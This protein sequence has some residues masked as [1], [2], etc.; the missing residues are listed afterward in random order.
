MGRRLPSPRQ[1]SASFRLPC[2]GLKACPALPEGS[3]SFPTSC[4]SEPPPH[5]LSC[6]S[7]L[8]VNLVSVPFPLGTHPHPHPTQAEHSSRPKT[9]QT[10]VG[11]TPFVRKE[12]ISKRGPFG[13]WLAIRPNLS[14]FEAVCRLHS[15]SLV[16]SLTRRLL[17]GPSGIDDRTP[18]HPLCCAG[19][20][21][22]KHSGTG[23]GA[24]SWGPRQGLP[25]PLP[26]G[27]SVRL[28]GQLWPR[29]PGGGALS[30]LWRLKFKIRGSAGLVAPDAVRGHLVPASPGCA[31]AAFAPPSLCVRLHLCVRVSSG[32]RCLA[33]TASSYLAHLCK[34]PASQ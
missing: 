4:P 22:L 34:D 10:H 20:G 15:P 19:A 13:A 32:P 31:D 5:S 6:L 8:L 24:C 28:W 12:R 11:P 26:R 33:L 16:G 23:R 29:A 2:R 18:P 30:Q 25:G 17:R 7:S 9:H 14:R 1:A 3:L 21:H 27:S